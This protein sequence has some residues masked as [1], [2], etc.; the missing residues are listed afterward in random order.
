MLNQ[1]L[2]NKEI[3]F[4]RLENKEQECLAYKAKVNFKLK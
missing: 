4:I 3:M 1:E 2:S